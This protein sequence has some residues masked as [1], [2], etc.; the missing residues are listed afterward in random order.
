MKKA[1]E[2]AQD[3]DGGLLE[4]DPMPWE[5]LEVAHILPHSL[6][7]LGGRSELVFHPSKL[8]SMVVN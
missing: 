6:T 4:E 8:Q 5:A 7:K 3:D 2:N 1:G